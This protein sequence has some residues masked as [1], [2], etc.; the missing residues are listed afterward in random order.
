M[1]ALPP[2]YLHKIYA[3]VLG[4]LIGVYLGRPFENWTYQDITSQLGTIKYYIHEKFNTPLV[5]ID[6]DVSGT[7]AFVRALQEHG[8]NPDLTSEEIGK[9]WLN[10]VIEKRTIFWW[11]GNGISTEHTTFN[12]LKK[13]GLTP[14]ET[15][16]IATN[17]RTLAE[18]IGA[19]IFIDGRCIPSIKVGGPRHARSVQLRDFEGRLGVY[20]YF[21]LGPLTLYLLQAGPCALREIQLSLRNYRGLLRASRM[22]V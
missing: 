3:G 9:T 19:Q 1:A 6:D 2:D 12:N 22:T 17:G 20:C 15:G 7:F 13:K 5:V 11:G 10:Q 16:S 8:A 18:Q 21:L 14:P 4:K